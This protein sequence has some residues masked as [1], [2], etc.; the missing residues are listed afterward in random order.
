MIAFISSED[1]G[2]F[3]IPGAGL[4]DLLKQLRALICLSDLLK[5]LR[6]SI[7]EHI[8]TLRACALVMYL[9]TPSL[10]FFCEHSFFL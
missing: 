8:K 5:Q 10:V 9:S 3:A 1:S 7:C 6:A 4:F 2:R